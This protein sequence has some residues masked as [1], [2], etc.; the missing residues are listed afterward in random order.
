MK[1]KNT[2]AQKLDKH[3]EAVYPNLE[4]FLL[5]NLIG[6]KICLGVSG[7]PDSL[8]LAYL[9]NIFSLKK[10]Y[11]MYAVI[12]DHGVRNDSDKEAEK[13]KT[14]LLK[15][16]IKTNI[17]KI[18]FKNK[19]NFHANAREKRYTKIYEFCKKNLIKNVLLAHHLDDQIENFYIR[20]SRGSGLTGL[21]PIKKKIKYKSIN[22]LRP[23]L[24]IRKDDLTKIT[25]KYFKFYVKDPSN[26]S[27][28]YLRSRVRKFRLF[29]ESEGFEDS[30][31]LSTLSNLEKARD[32]L[33]Y[34]SDLSFKKFFKAKG[35][36][37]YI[38]KKLFLEPKEII[39][40]SVS[41]LLVKNKNYPSR[42]KGI[43]RLIAD[44]KDTNNK[45]VTLGGYIFENG[46]NSVKV[47]KENRKR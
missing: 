30:R 10:G 25:K 17:F 9:S 2:N 27:D 15:H 46:L 8:A 47:S 16:K 26:L 36:N 39:F 29:M 45:K 20:L 11:K 28:K 34:Y 23:F 35:H 12:I 41:K 24:S 14:E 42:S 22:F 38:S 4:K 7:G 31:L 44:L 21:S 1:R 43:E 13:V 32:A 40:R 37:T 19:S 18:K 6:K 3:L 33:D 5:S